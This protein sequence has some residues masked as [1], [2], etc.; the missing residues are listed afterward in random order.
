MEY[1]A[2]PRRMQSVKSNK[3]SSWFRVLKTHPNIRRRIFCF[4]HAGGA[5]SYFKQWPEAVPEDTEFVVVQYPGR[6]E[7]LNHP[8][9]NNMEDMVRA[10][11]D[12]LT[13]N[14]HLLQIPFVIFGHSMGASIGY[15][16]ILELQKAGLRL[17]VALVASATDAPG[18]ANP[19][20]F[21][22]SSDS[23]L[24]EEIVRLSPSLSFL[25]EHEEL[26]EMVLPALRADYQ[27]IE[28]YGKRN[29]P[30]PPL[31]IPIKKLIGDNDSELS[32]DDALLW[33]NQT[34]AN[35]SLQSFPGGHFYLADHYEAVI[36]VFMESYKDS[37][38]LSPS[39]SFQLP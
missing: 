30:R 14:P 37:S 16:L 7:R 39:L 21:H 27:L 10:L 6:E 13:G 9:I 11:F 1:T 36:R 26:L 17:P 18:Y 35:F 15:E 2:Q 8:C 29:E 23:E 12:Q 20:Q 38:T 19:T 28:T 32:R 3:P 25:K 33:K 4:P 31:P 34:S 24:V 22:I 5:A